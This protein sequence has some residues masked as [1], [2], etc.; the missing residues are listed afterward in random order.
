MHGYV[1]LQPYEQYLN[2]VVNMLLDIEKTDSRI[3]GVYK[4]W[5]NENK[6]AT[7]TYV[8]VEMNCDNLRKELLKLEALFPE[9]L[10]NDDYNH[11]VYLT[12]RILAAEF[13]SKL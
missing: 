3:L 1:E 4:I 7:K 10:E 11:P 12:E 6:E 9:K 13:S 8:W 2:D 5:L